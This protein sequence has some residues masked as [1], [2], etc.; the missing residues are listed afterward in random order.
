[1]GPNKK[2]LHLLQRDILVESKELFT[3][4]VKICF[5]GEKFT[6][7]VHGAGRDRVSL[8]APK[9]TEELRPMR[10]HCPKEQSDFILDYGLEVQPLSSCI[11]GGWHKTWKQQTHTQTQMMTP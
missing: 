3:E 8:Q 7:Q 6:L 2:Q 5:P 4:V 11:L 9:I 10:S 1:M